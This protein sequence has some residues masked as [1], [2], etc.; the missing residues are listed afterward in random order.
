MEKIELLKNKILL[1]Y[2]FLISNAG[3]SKDF[4]KES[5][6]LVNKAYDE[7]NIKILKAGERDIYVNVKEMPLKMQLELKQIYKEKLDLDLEIFQKLF[8]KKIDE[9]IK[10]G[11]IKNDD[12]YRLL[13][14]KMDNTTEYKTDDEI[15][16][17]NKML[18]EYIKII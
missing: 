4:F 9:I 7:K 2:G 13:L 3:M 16:L 10:K 15:K 12:E 14:E 1:F 6:E 8:S 5:I 18:I 17:I 11:L